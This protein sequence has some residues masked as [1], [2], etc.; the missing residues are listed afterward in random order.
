M[1]SSEGSA[2]DGNNP[3]DGRIG[4]TRISKLAG[5]TQGAKTRRNIG[6]LSDQNGR[7]SSSFNTQRL[8]ALH[9]RMAKLVMQGFQFSL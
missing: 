2:P 1:V 7:S 5:G 3:V 6:I 9:V 8:E 4:A